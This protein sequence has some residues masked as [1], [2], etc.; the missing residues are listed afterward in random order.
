M[1]GKG[2]RTATLQFSESG[3]SLNGPD[4]FTELLFL[5][6]SLPNP[7]FTELPST[8]SL[9]N[10]SCFN[11]KCFVASPKLLHELSSELFLEPLWC[12]RY[13]CRCDASRPVRRMSPPAPSV[14]SGPPRV[15]SAHVAEAQGGAIATRLALTS[16]QNHPLSVLSLYLPHSQSR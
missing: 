16:S 10:P 14:E 12:Q 4:L 9:K 6:K 2:I 8:F 13:T 7:S 5:W 1:F 11:G 15:A 3:G